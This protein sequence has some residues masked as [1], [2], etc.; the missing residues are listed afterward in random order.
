[1]NV[2]YH[3]LLFQ[4][5]I[6]LLRYLSRFLAQAD[7]SQEDGVLSNSR[8]DNISSTFSSRNH[9]QV[10]VGSI[11][12]IANDCYSI[13]TLVNDSAQSSSATPYFQEVLLYDGNVTNGNVVYATKIENN[14]YGFNNITYDF[15][16]IIPEDQSSG[17][18]D[19]TAYYFYV[20]LS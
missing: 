16:M 18:A 3:L 19:S 20:E 12:I 14:I 2:K 10:D 6:F 13:F 9:T 15:Q 4:W 7:D 11:T 1:M 17:S 5:W 8:V